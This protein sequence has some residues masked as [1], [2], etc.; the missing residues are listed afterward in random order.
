M[1]TECN[2]VIFYDLFDDRLM[3]IHDFSNKVANDEII[4]ISF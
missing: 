3:K 4:N 2:K 1:V